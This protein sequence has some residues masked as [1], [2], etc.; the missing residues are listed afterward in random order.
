MKEDEKR[1]VAVAIG[2]LAIALAGIA[3]WYWWEH[4]LSHDFHKAA[5]DAVVQLDLFMGVKGDDYLVA[6][7]SENPFS[8]AQSVEGLSLAVHKAEVEVST[9]AD[10]EAAVELRWYYES[11]T[12]REQHCKLR[13]GDA[14][15]SF[16]QA[17][18]YNTLGLKRVE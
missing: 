11:V 10:K 15:S 6:G 13:G 1:N 9:K 14:V 17:V 5:L 12:N 7:C 8:Y 3:G 18:I 4:T 16:N 2:V